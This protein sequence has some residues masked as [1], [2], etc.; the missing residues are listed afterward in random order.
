L[1]KRQHS[2]IDETKLSLRESGKWK[3]I[4]KPVLP[5]NGYQ[6][7]PNILVNPTGTISSLGPVGDVVFNRSLKNH[8]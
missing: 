1:F 3:K 8:C 4:I 5:A 7:T 6:K 2:Q